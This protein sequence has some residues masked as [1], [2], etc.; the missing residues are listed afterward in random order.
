MTLKM[1]NQTLDRMTRSAVSHV[2]QCGHHW[3]TPRHRSADSFGNTIDPNEL[4]IMKQTILALLCTI[5]STFSEAAAPPESFTLKAEPRH[6]TEKSLIL[7]LIIESQSG[8][9]MRLDQVGGLGLS[10]SFRRTAAGARQ[11]GKVTLSLT[12]QDGRVRVLAGLE[13]F[14]TSEQERSVL[15]NTAEYSIETPKGAKLDSLLTMTATN[16]V[17]KLDQPLKIGMLDGKPLELAIGKR[18]HE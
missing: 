3:R 15:K 6:E 16:G 12:E 5:V 2:L 1:P 13:T 17:Y 18:T 11:K 8:E 4:H 7:M 10:S 9:V 14:F